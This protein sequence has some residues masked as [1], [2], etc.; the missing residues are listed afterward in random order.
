MSFQNGK[1]ENYLFNIFLRDGNIEHSSI[2][3]K[4]VKKQAFEQNKS[5]IF[6]LCQEDKALNLEEKLKSSNG[7]N[8]HTAE[9]V[10]KKYLF[11]KLIK[12]L[13]LTF[14]YFFRKIFKQE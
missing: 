5:F 3:S 9:V 12:I 2:V 11:N 14:F 10:R 1:K 8:L 13:I 4:L 6:K 7:N